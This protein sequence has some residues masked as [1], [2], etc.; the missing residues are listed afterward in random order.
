LQDLEASTNPAERIPEAVHTLCQSFN[1]L[2]P[3]MHLLGKQR[4]RRRLSEAMMWRMR[5]WEA[6]NSCPEVTTAPLIR[7]VVIVAP[8]RTGTTFLH[9][10]LAQDPQFR[11]VR[12]WEALYA[13]RAAVTPDSFRS[14]S[15]T[16][17]RRALLRSDLGHMYRMHPELADLHPMNEDE[18]DECFGFL[19]TSFL[20]PSFLFYGPIR[21]YMTW[22]EGLNES[23]WDETYSCY[24]VH[25][26]LLAWFCPG[27]RILLKNPVHIWNLG[28]LQ[29]AFPDAVRVHL[30]RDPVVSIRSFCR[31]LSVHYALSLRAADAREVGQLV[32]QFYRV[33]L[34]R[35]IAA[36]RTAG[37]GVDI[38]IS[39]ND[40][41]RDPMAA[42]H[43]IYS[44]AGLHLA[45]EVENQMQ[46]SLIKSRAP[47]RLRPAPESGDFGLDD[48][49]L[50]KLLAGYEAF[51]MAG[52]SGK[53]P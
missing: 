7:P 3:R 18:P 28:A 9:R 39:F 6:M 50:R 48:G 40:L 38:D 31:L 30:H 2:G 24:R 34:G 45:S 8:F 42:V 44:N 13:P 4:I 46:S 33:A 49:E 41:I 43:F 21:A 20:S 53:K 37:Q 47:D 51:Q 52:N 29:R 35:A 16:D 11:W 10:L 22:L 19:E 26:Q 32:V 36:R 5:L 12:P 17:E 23:A 27:Q 1:A 25:V 15:Q 14:C